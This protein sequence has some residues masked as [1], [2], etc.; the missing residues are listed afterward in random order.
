MTPKD[1]KVGMYM[2][3]ENLRVDTNFEKK[4]SLND[5]IVMGG[6]ETYNSSMMTLS[7]LGDMLL[8]LYTPKNEQ[9]HTEAKNMLS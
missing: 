5:S 8:V 9:E 1:G 6:K 2:R 4:Y 7:F 3:Y